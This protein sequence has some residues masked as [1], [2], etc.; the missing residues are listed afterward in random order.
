MLATR[1]RS[2]LPDLTEDQALQA[3]AIASISGQG[4]DIEQWHKP[5]YRNPHHT[6]S[7]IAL[8]GGGSH[9]KPGEI[10]LAHMGGVIS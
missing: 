6:A 10:S 7:A 2:V 1:M 5:P 8:V 9:P 3:A 4:F